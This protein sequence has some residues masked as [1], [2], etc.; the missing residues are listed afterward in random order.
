MNMVLTWYQENPHATAESKLP[1]ETALIGG[2][3]LL[4]YRRK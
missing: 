3:T 1:T 2:E 4:T